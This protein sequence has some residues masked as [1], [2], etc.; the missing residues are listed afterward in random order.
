LNERFWPIYLTFDLEGWPWP[1]TTQNVQLHEIHMHAKYQVAIFNN[2]KVIAKLKPRLK[3]WD[4]HNEW[5][6]D[7]PKQYAPNLSI[8]GHKNKLLQHNMHY[9]HLKHLNTSG[10]LV[11]RVMT[12]SCSSLLFCCSLLFSCV[13][14]ATSSRT[15]VRSSPRLLLAVLSP[16]S[17][18]HLDFS[19]LTS[20]SSCCNVTNDYCHEKCLSH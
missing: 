2:A 5:Q 13:R 15:E 18:A 6:T 11:C 1:F 10:D 19:R 7:R 12:C 4:T 3:F 20:S 17:C 8:R 16:S 14:V 9:E